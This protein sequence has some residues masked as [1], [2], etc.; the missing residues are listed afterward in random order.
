MMKLIANVLCAGLM[1]IVSG[2]A[3]ADDGTDTYKLVCSGCHETGINGA[4]KLE[5]KVVWKHRVKSSMD[6]LYASTMNG[7]CKFFVQDLRKD[8]TDE[9]IR[10]AVDYMISRVK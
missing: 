2:A 1:L 4:P 3:M 9:E 10:A 8:L 6:K 7:K 5:D